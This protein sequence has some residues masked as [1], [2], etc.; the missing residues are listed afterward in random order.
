[1]ALNIPKCEHHISL[2][3]L[4]PCMRHSRCQQV[5]RTQI[6]A[7]PLV[8]DTVGSGSPHRNV[9]TGD[10]RQGFKGDLVCVRVCMCQRQRKIDS[11]LFLFSLFYFLCHLCST[12]W[13]LSRVEASCL[14]ILQ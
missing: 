10:D 2:V 13:L 1:M 3:C 11:S 4:S 12:V 6:P 8:S 5:G 7:K 9:C 14:N